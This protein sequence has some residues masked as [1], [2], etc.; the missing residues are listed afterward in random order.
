MDEAYDAELTQKIADMLR[1]AGTLTLELA[2]R[3]LEKRRYARTA[4]LLRLCR[5]IMGTQ[6]QLAFRRKGDA[7]S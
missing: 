4:K 6:Q 3:E 1:E 2:V 7:R 5:G